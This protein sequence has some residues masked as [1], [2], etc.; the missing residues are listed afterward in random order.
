MDSRMG[1]WPLLERLVVINIDLT[2][3]SMLAT[4]HECMTSP[5]YAAMP[6]LLHWFVIS[7]VYK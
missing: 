5:L 1:V 4:E 7:I 6:T 3:K 2:N